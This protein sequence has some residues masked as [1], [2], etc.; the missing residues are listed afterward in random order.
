MRQHRLTPEQHLLNKEWFEVNRLA[1]LLRKHD[2]GALRLALLMRV[3]ESLRH[4][5]YNR[6]IQ[7]QAKHKTKAMVN[8]G[9]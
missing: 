1:W 8:R 4:D 9:L 6:V 5:V 2:G 3:P 7:L